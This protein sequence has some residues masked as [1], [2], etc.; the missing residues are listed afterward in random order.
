MADK[1]DFEFR[2]IGDRQGGQHAVSYWLFHQFNGVLHWK[3]NAGQKHNLLEISGF[4][5]MS[6][7]TKWSDNTVKRF[8]A[9]AANYEDKTLK[10]VRGYFYPQYSKE[11][12]DIIILR[13]PYNLF[14]SR[15][16]NW[17][18]NSPARLGQ[19]SRK[20]E[21]WKQKAKEVINKECYFIDFG[22]WF[23]DRGYREHILSWFPEGVFIFT[24]EGKEDMS[25]YPRESV[26]ISS[27]DG[28]KFDGK[29]SQMDLLH[30]YKKMIDDP[31]MKKVFVND[32]VRGLSEQI[33]GKVM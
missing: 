6:G 8:V 29:A 15:I 22:K 27:F 24:D 23:V 5:S 7:F 11:R 9:I 19:F 1:I 31:L 33:F 10:D 3:N 25:N 20:L 32:E 13:D 30:R 14:A 16:H 18:T 21:I 12:Y 2:L 17:R 4:P 28:R 26:G